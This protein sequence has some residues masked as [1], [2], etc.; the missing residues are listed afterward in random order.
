VEAEGKALAND[1]TAEPPPRHDCGGIGATN[2]S[3]PC[4]KPSSER[5]V[6]GGVQK[7]LFE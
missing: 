3:L 1:S 4:S 6:R 5:L 7:V 2:V